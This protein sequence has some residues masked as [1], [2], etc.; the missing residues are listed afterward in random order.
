MNMI[1]N[2]VHDSI[3]GGHVGMN[4]TLELVQRKYYWP[5]MYKYIS[6][7]INSCDKCQ[8]NKSS[9]QS[10]SGLLQPLPIPN[11]RWEQI[12]IDFI[13]PLP[14]TKNNHNF[15]L[16]VV[17]KLS[18]MAH[19]IPTHTNITAE[20]TARLIFKN[21]IRYHGIPQS[22]VSDRD[23]RFTSSFWQELWKILGTKLNMS[24]SF[25]PQTD[26][27]TERQNRTLEEYL[28][29]FINLEQD[30]WDELLVSA[31]IAYNNSIHASTNYTPYYL[32]YGQ[33]PNLSI[34]LNKNNN[35]NINNNNVKELLDELQHD[36]NHAVECLLEAQSR[37][38]YYANMNRREITF[39]IGDLVM[40]STNNLRNLDKTPKLS[41]K[42]IGPFKI[43]KKISDVVYELELPTDMNIHPSFHISKLK[44]YNK[45]DDKLFPNRAVD[46]S[47][48][49]PGPETIINGKE[50]YEVEKII[51]KRLVKRGREK[52]P[53]PEYLV[54]WKGYSTH[55]AT[56][57]REKELT[58]SKKLIQEYEDQHP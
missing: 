2:E 12:T 23:T 43:I 48:S 32:N 25:H 5:K 46:V 45:N 37:Q 52:Y 7:Y 6:T 14:L 40:L 3:I 19:Y 1:L 30:N 20:G 31:E 22:I 13:G 58:M 39:N 34:I 15:I 56:W 8:S 41:S 11:K 28:R 36:I 17:D 27:Q 29:S 35:N 47:V 33:H 44:K 54:K 16:V 38:E 21:I 50:A 49:R 24:T 57:K 4:K 53:K 18:K 26:G 9:N 10:T 51:D 55:E 42:Y